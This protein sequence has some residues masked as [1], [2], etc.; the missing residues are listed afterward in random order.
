[1]NL[2][3]KSWFLVNMTAEKLLGNSILILLSTLMC[4]AGKK[5]ILFDPYTIKF[6]LSLKNSALSY[7]FNLNSH[8]NIDF[9]QM[10]C[11]LCGEKF[12]GLY[13]TQQHYVEKHEVDINNYFL[14]I[15][16]IMKKSYLFREKCQNSEYH[17]LSSR[18]G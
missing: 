3:P 1:M 14:T 7:G 18:D 8:F 10:N 17:F 2:F 12:D 16:S 6:L 4:F 11:F 13:H 5:F 15:C 9:F